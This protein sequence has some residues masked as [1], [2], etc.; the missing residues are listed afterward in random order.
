MDLNN[1]VAAIAALT[2]ER[3]ELDQQLEQVFTRIDR[4]CRQLEAIADLIAS[5][6]SQE[7][8][9]YL[10]GYSHGRLALANEIRKILVEQNHEQT[11][12]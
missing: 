2:Q 8:R 5:E 11:K 3:K 6:A 1:A 10:P 4:Q 9:G 7:W 12:S